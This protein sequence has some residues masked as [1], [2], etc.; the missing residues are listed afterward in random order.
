M[1]V[2][3]SGTRYAF[4]MALALCAVASHFSLQAAAGCHDPLVQHSAHRRLMQNANANSQSN[5]GTSIAIANSQATQAAAS[6]A[7]KASSTAVAQAVS[8]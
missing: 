4:C 6:E 7:A 3:G 1:V 2:A 8:S 5:G